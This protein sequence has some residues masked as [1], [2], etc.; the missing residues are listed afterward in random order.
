MFPEVTAVKLGPSIDIKG[1]NPVKNINET[2]ITAIL[3]NLLIIPP[4]H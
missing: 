1:M 2:N 4:E 3:I